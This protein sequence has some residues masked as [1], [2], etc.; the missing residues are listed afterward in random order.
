MN[1]SDRNL[2]RLL[3][4]GYVILLVS[5]WPLWISSGGFPQVPLLRCFESVPR[6]IEWGLIGLQIASLLTMAFDQSSAHR[7]IA[8][9]VSAICSLGLVCG[10]QHRFQPW[11]WQFFI[12]SLVLAAA[13]ASTA[14]S[15]WR[16]LT[17]GIYFWS[18]LSKLDSEFGLQHGQFLLEGLFKSVG[19]TNFLRSWPSGI[20]HSVASAFPAVEFLIALGLSWQITRRTAVYGAAMMHLCLFLA[21]GPLG[22]NHQPGVLV[23]NLFFLAQN[24]IVFRRQPIEPVQELNTPNKTNFGFGGRFAKLVVAAALIWP[25]TESLGYCDHWPAWALYASKPERVSVYVH[26]TELS[27]LPDNLR[28]YL[29][30]QTVI[31]DWHP[32]RID[33]WSLV[34][35]YVPIYPQDRFQVGIALGL[36]QT[37]GLNELRIVIE[38]PANRWTGK[39]TVREYVGLPSIEKLADSFRFNA[40]PR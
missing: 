35:A 37:C 40:R 14:S 25:A 8:C 32:F 7:R 1:N 6:P 16:W 2:F 31:D 38:S 10:N 3:A 5:T 39:R 23:W 19:L 21:L 24:A 36:A 30:A 29:P 33:R 13:Q 15:A 17:I 26:E 4:G 18:G 20:R 22:Q 27:K 9:V 28:I 11:V 12:L 34:A